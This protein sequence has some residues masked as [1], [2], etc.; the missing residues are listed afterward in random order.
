[1]KIHLTFD[2]PIFVEPAVRPVSPQ[3]ADLSEFEITAYS[4]K[5]IVAEKMR[6]LLQQQTKWPRPR[7]LYDLWFMLCRSREHFESG[8]LKDLFIEKCKVRQISPDLAGLTSEGLREWNKDAWR[9]QLTPM[10]KT[11]PG[12][13]QVWSDWVTTCRKM[14]T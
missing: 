6:A 3:Y 5:E 4:K 11:V 8:E 9:N 7:D 10:M 1:V 14:F 13:D 12:F 2:E